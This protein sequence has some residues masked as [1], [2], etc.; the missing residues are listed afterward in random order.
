MWQR[1]IAPKFCW[2]PFFVLDFVPTMIRV[3]S[4]F[5]LLNEPVNVISLVVSLLVQQLSG[6]VDSR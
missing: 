5:V 4:E 6:G 3:P 2:I 1:H